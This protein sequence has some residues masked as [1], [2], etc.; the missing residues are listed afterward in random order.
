[1]DQVFDG[2]KLSSEIKR[3]I[4]SAIIRALMDSM[5]S[6]CNAKMFSATEAS[7][8]SVIG[9]NAN[10]R[11]LINAFRDNRDDTLSAAIDTLKNHAAGMI[12]SYAD[13]GDAKM[14]AEHEF[15]KS[16]TVRFAN[17]VADVYVR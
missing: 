8:A 16:S 10:P 4:I 6:G 13:D 12:T 9:W 15:G 3:S 7:Y 11:T 17:E 1:M 5:P 2:Y 14:I